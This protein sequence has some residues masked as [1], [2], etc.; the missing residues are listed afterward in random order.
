MLLELMVGADIVAGRLGGRK[1]TFVTVV[2][3]IEGEEDVTGL[4]KDLKED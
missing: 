3:Y 1:A 4:H 2:R